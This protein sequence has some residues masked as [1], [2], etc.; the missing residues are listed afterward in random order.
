LTPGPVDCER[1]GAEAIVEWVDITSFADPSPVYLMNRAWCTTPGC[2]NEDGS[3]AVMPPDRPGELTR[4]DRRWIRRHE[5][6][7]E[8]YGRTAAL[9]DE[10]ID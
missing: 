3:T 10:M 1:C 4:E 8:E 9:L 6:L 5:R 7:A 2:V